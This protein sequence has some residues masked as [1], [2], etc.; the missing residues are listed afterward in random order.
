MSNVRVT[1]SLPSVSPIQR[2][3]Q[4]TEIA[5]RVAN[6]ALPWTVQDVVAP[7]SLQE[8]LF[9]DVAPGDYEYRAVVVDVDDQRS[10][11]AFASASV[12]FALP[13]SVTEFVAVVE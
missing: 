5:F 2:A 1:W 10:P 6:V 4:H 13:G 11:E 8:L 7:D 9:V 3:I 12:P